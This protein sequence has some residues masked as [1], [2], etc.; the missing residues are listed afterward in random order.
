MLPSLSR[1]LL[2]DSS[3]LLSMLDISLP[4]GIYLDVSRCSRIR[5]RTCEGLQ[6]VSDRMYANDVVLRGTTGPRLGV[7]FH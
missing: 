3:R 5:G 6:S 2:R 4:L 1:N 7:P